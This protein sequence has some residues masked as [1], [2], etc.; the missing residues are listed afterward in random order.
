MTFCVDTICLPNKLLS[1]FQLTIYKTQTFVQ[2]ITIA[3]RSLPFLLS[4]RSMA[5]ATIYNSPFGAKRARS[6]SGARSRFIPTAFGSRG[7]QRA[8]TISL[9]IIIKMNFSITHSNI[10]RFNIDISARLISTTVA[11]DVDLPHETDTTW[12]AIYGQFVDHDLTSTPIQSLS[13]IWLLI[14]ILSL[15]LKD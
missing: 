11:I 3:T 1:D 9:G 15:K 6:S 10:I 2:L 8:V 13:N 14:Y 12:V 7:R 5:R 4:E